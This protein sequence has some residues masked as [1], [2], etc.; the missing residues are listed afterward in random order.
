MEKYSNVLFYVGDIAIICLVI[1][2]VWIYKKNN[3]KKYLK[4][5]NLSLNDYEIDLKKDFVNHQLNSNEN[6]AFSNADIRKSFT[7]VKL[8]MLSLIEEKLFSD[9]E[10]FDARPYDSIFFKV[11]KKTFYKS[12]SKDKLIFLNTLIAYIVKRA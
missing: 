6:D 4:L 8:N 7:Q 2:I 1:Y 10:F 11:L 12:T 3:A 9:S 5:I